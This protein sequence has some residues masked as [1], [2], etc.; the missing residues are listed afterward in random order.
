MYIYVY[1][2]SRVQDNSVCNTDIFLVQKWSICTLVHN[3]SSSASFVMK[4]ID[5]GVLKEINKFSFDEQL[6]TTDNNIFPVYFFFE[7]WTEDTRTPFFSSNK[8]I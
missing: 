6:T 1:K 7:E 3:T 8:R 4:I 5:K 2:Y